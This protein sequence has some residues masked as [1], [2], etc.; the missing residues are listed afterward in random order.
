[1]F[2]MFNAVLSVLLSLAAIFGLVFLVCLVFGY[3]VSFI[4]WFVDQDGMAKPK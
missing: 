3:I 2:F 1:M 4:Q